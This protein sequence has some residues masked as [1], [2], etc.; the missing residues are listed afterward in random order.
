M[1]RRKIVRAAVMGVVRGERVLV[2]LFMADA[3]V[4]VAR[5]CRCWV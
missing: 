3:A 1:R 4:A 5:C 2:F